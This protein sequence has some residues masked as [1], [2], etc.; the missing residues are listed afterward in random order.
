MI[1]IGTT[2][3]Y[4]I[5]KLKKNVNALAA[6]LPAYFIVN[7]VAITQIYLFIIKLQTI[8]VIVTVLV[9]EHIKSRLEIN[10][11]INVCNNCFSVYDEFL[12]I[13]SFV[14]L[15]N[16]LFNTFCTFSECNNLKK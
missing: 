2:N 5:I 13:I 6:P 11:N 14:K 7:N 8:T 15:I 1:L 16:N 12:I 9:E 3:Y 4:I 10:I